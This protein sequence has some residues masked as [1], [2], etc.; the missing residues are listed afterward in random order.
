MLSG[1]KI[2]DNGARVTCTASNAIG[3]ES[4][5]IKLDIPCKK[6]WEHLFDLRGYTMSW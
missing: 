6:Y 2:K 1:L 5:S 4:S 3:T